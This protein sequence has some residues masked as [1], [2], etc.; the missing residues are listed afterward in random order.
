[1]DLIFWSPQ[2]LMR[3]IRSHSYFCTSNAFSF[4]A[5]RCFSL[6]LNFSSLYV[7]A[8]SSSGS[9]CLEFAKS[10]NLPVIILSRIPLTAISPLL[11]LHSH[12][13]RSS[14]IAPQVRKILFLNLWGWRDGSVIKSTCFSCRGLGFST[15]YPSDSSQLFA[16]RP[17]F[18][19]I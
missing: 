10:S 16:V 8:L 18:Q 19:G 1:M 5:F 4:V 6:Y 12:L 17:Q 13:P 15:Q 9:H 2:F 14:I 3:N 7:Q 11:R